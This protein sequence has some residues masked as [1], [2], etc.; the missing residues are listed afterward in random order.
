MMREVGNQIPHCGRI[1]GIVRDIAQYPVSQNP[2]HGP[3]TDLHFPGAYP[4]TRMTDSATGGHD[5]VTVGGRKLTPGVLLDV[6]D[7][8]R[9][10]GGPLLLEKA[11]IG[12]ISWGAKT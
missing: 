4:H 11:I 2:G 9:A 12:N 7:A 8:I 3:P 5:Q 10:A 1:E 6:R